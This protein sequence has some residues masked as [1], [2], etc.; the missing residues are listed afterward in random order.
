MSRF[1]KL[2]EKFRRSEEIA[3]DRKQNL[4]DFVKPILAALGY[5]TGYIHSIWVG[6]SEVSIDYRWSRRG[7]ENSQDIVLPLAIFT[8]DDPLAVAKEYKEAKEKAR[9]E[10]DR[11]EKI[12][13]I[14]RLQK[15]L[16]NEK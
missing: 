15:E 4:D 9:A 7:C 1:Q 6:P 14:Q 12:R 8:A 3:S 10:Q 13:H 2:L 16:E 11:Q 5:S